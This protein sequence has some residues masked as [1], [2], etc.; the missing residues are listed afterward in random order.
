VSS[1][2]S[3]VSVAVLQEYFN[4]NCHCIQLVL[5]NVSIFKPAY[6]PAAGSF[7]GKAY[8]SNSAIYT[9]DPK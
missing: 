5:V 6:L 4:F 1:K 9:A 3:G 8:I 2:K 7:N